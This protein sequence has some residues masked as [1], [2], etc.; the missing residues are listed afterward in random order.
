MPLKNIEERRKYDRMRHVRDKVKRK[1][2]AH[3]YYL[4]HK[5]E[6]LKRRRTIKRICLFCN[7]EFFVRPEEIK[8]GK[9]KFCTTK[10]MGMAKRKRIEVIC[11]V[12][13]NRF[14]TKPYQIKNG[15]GKYC[16]IKC[17][18]KDQIGKL[19]YG[20]AKGK[21]FPERSG[22][23]AWNWKGKI[24]SLKSQIY[25]HYKARQ[26]RSDV[27]TKDNFTCQWCG[28]RS[29]LEAHH[30]K[31]QYKII[32]ENKIKT[33]EEALNC[34]ELWNIN[35][36]ITLCKNC[37]NKTKKGN[38]RKRGHEKMLETQWQK[39]FGTNKPIQ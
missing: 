26:W 28:N 3:S 36:G 16:S 27:F 20:W 2:S 31:E 19:C 32:E 15:W 38:P 5:E 14:F 6:L 4:L 29:Y 21:K 10:C 25:R 30:I 22:S 17:K 11:K 8:I 23:N 13:S 9:G 24:T 33:L 1:N 7:K 18:Q 34:E 39:R 37:H 35:N 12:C